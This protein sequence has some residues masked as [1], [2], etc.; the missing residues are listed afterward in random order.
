MSGCTLAQQVLGG[1]GAKGLGPRCGISYAVF[2]P[3]GR[4]AK[5]VP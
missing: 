3:S 1:V 4:R 2:A 5:H